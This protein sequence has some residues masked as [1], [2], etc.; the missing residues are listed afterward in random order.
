MD[1]LADFLAVEPGQRAALAI[2]GVENDQIGNAVFGDRRIEQRIDGSAVAGV[3]RARRR[4]GFRDEA[5]E[6]A[7]IARGHRHRHALL[8]AQPRQRC[9]QA[10][11]GADDKDGFSGLG[12][13]FSSDRSNAR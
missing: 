4:A 1:R 2:A 10:R 6:L 11:A 8:R 13:G 12:H 5:G 3:A 9:T 7:G